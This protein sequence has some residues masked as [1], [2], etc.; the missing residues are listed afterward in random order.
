MSIKVLVIDDD[1]TLTS[2]LTDALP[3]RGFVVS[4]A[5]SGTEGVEQARLIKPDVIV[6]DLMMPGIS[7][8]QVCELIRAFSQVPILILS[9]LVDSDG[10]MLALENGADDYMVK[11]VPHEAL[12]ARLKRLS[13][14]ARISLDDEVNQTK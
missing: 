5:N 8:W 1:P 11:P 2:V 6:L 4:A 14:Q 12:A 7:G 13:R 3:S 9:S 10:V